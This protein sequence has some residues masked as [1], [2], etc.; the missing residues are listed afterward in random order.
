MQ[1]ALPLY[2][3]ASHNVQSKRD[4]ACIVMLIGSPLHPHFPF[5][6]YIVEDVRALQKNL[7]LKSV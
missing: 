5:L 1:A 7:S 4:C 2:L 3:H 6:L